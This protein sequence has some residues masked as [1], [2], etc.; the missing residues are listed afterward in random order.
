GRGTGAA[1][2]CPML[3][4]RAAAG[5]IL[6]SSMHN[7]RKGRLQNSPA[8]R[9]IQAGKAGGGVA[10]AATAETA[11]VL[12]SAAIRSGR[13]MPLAWRQAAAVAAEPARATTVTSA[14]PPKA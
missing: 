3:A 10:P 12:K 2:S 4:W 9:G 14:S 8:A 13:T 5:L 6:S 1:T 7:A 11:A